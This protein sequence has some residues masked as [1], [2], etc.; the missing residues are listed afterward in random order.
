VPEDPVILLACPCEV[1]RKLLR[2]LLDNDGFS[3]REAIGATDTL[4]DAVNRPDLILLDTLLWE[5]A[6]IGTAATLRRDPRTSMIPLILFGEPPPDA[7]SSP[8]RSVAWFP[9]K[10]FSIELLLETIR[11]HLRSRE[12]SAPPAASSANVRVTTTDAHVARLDESPVRQAIQALPHLTPFE[13]SI[14]EAITTNCA[15]VQIINHISGIVSRDPS[16][17]V[18]LLAQA[19]AAKPAESP[20]VTNVPEAVR[21]LGSRPFYEMVDRISPL[22]LDPDSPWD[23]GYFWIHGVATAQI[24]ALLSKSLG[25]CSPGE[26][27]AAGLLH[28]LG[29][30]VLANHFPASFEALIAAEQNA[31]TLTPAWEQSVIG[32]D[33]GT[34]AAWTL[35]RFELPRA[36]QEAV[37]AHHDPVLTARQISGSSRVLAIIV[38][39]ADQL[40]DALYPGD[41]P[42]APLRPLEQAFT[43]VLDRTNQDFARI[44]AAARQVF[45]D[46]LTELRFLFPLS[47]SRPYYYADK[48]LDQ[49]LYLAPGAPTWDLIRAYLTVRSKAVITRFAGLSNLTGS[50]LTMVVNL[51]Y[52]PG[53]TT[54]VEA[55]SSLVSTGFLNG[56]KTV[57]LMAAPPPQAVI[58][59]VPDSCRFVTLPCQAAPWVR[60]LA[61]PISSAPLAGPKLCVA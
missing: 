2:H 58:D 39:A 49:V 37:A 9:R 17:A 16:L 55:L 36:L 20:P 10:G 12:P 44:L 1:E 57:I 38:Q 22:T 24:A 45:T 27:A 46:L 5:K 42:L 23:P 43:K 31:D 32:V 13:F 56:H 3:V 30:F 40:A 41:P 6:A 47:A 8:P 61:A 33:H 11:T 26:A 15:R 50:D 4:S 29:F 52:R 25:L 34:L 51:A 35:E 18:A 59:L 60:W 28:D 53:T 54:Q 21:I 14:A 48:P 7:N 19:N